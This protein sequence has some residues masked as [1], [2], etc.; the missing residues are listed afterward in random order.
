M[1]KYER[2]RFFD[3]L[4]RLRAL[5]RLRSEY[6]ST[7]VMSVRDTVDYALRLMEHSDAQAPGRGGEP[8]PVIRRSE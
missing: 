8:E 2:R 4:C 5:Y 1:S 6:D 3:D 7:S